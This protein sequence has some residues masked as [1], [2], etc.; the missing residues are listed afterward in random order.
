MTAQHTEMTAFYTVVS[1]LAAAGIHCEIESDEKDETYA[2]YHFADGSHLTWG[3]HSITGAENSATH[4]IS[5]HG[6]LDGF[7]TNDAGD[8]DRDFTSGD[9]ATDAAALVTWVTDLADRHGRA[10]K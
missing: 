9:F 8:E 2:A 5:A 6:R 1:H 4:P 7:Y 3:A 10:P